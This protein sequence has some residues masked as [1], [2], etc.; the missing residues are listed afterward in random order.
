MPA[1]GQLPAHIQLMA[2]FPSGHALTLVCSWMNASTPTLV[3]YGHRATVNLSPIGDHFEIIPQNEFLSEVNQEEFS[4]LLPQD[5]RE[6][7]RNWF[8]CI[9]SGKPPNAD[10]E[11]GIRAQTV[12]SLAELSNRRKITCLFNETTRKIMDGTGKEIAPLTYDVN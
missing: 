11:L 8:E 10:I 2:E 6:H 7:E 12:L 5:I 3:L 9:R 1:P 4:A